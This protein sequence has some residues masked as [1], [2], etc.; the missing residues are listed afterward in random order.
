[1]QL[2]VGDDDRAPVAEAGHGQRGDLAQRT[3]EVQG[4]GQRQ[5]GVGRE[6]GHL[7]GPLAQGPE[8]LGRGGVPRVQPTA[9]RGSG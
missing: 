3:P 1:M 4:A 5:A 2:P 6:A 7:V 9:V 8:L